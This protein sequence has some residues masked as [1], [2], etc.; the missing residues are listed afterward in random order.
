M[1]QPSRGERLHI[2]QRILIDHGQGLGYHEDHSNE[3]DEGREELQAQRNQPCGIGLS[4]TSTANVV[5]ACIT[6]CQLGRL[7]MQLLMYSP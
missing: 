1:D 4:L 7:I 5:R 3:E 6:T 2:C